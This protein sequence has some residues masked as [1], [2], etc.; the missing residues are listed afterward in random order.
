M[1]IFL[2]IN[3]FLYFLI[4]CNKNINKNE[5][6]LDESNFEPWPFKIYEFDSEGNILNSEIDI[7]DFQHSRDCQ[8]CHPNHV[9]EWKLSSHYRA[10]NSQIFKITFENAKESH[11]NEGDRFC[12][13]CHSPQL[14]VTGLFESDLEDNSLASEI[15]SENIGCDFC[16]TQ[17]RLNFN[18]L[19]VDDHSLIDAEYFINPGEGIKYGSIVDPDTNN[20][21]HHSVYNSIYKDSRTCLPCHN[22]VIRDVP[23]HMTM[24]EW[25]SDP[26]NDMADNRSCQSCHM[27]YNG[28]YHSHMF[29]GIDIDLT[30]SLDHEDNQ[31]RIAS[32]T[33]LLDSAAI[34]YFSNSQ[35][36]IKS[37]TFSNDTLK[38]PFTIQNKTAHN[39]PTGTSEL[40]EAWIELVVY[41]KNDEPICEFGTIESN[42][43]FLKYNSHNIIFTSWL[44]NG[45]DTVYSS[46][47]A[48][49]IINNSLKINETFEW[50]YSCY[51]PADIQDYVKVKSRMRIRPVKPQLFYSDPAFNEYFYLLDNIPIFDI[52]QSKIE[53]IVYVN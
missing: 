49:D 27:S 30:K 14:F 52:E 4:S 53:K 47:E 37:Y 33:S 20:N 35:D 28:E 45:Q 15:A 23:V 51:I 39:I 24:A 18:S 9:E 11:F 43:D 32:I 40:R 19:D 46:I 17:T 1:K 22:M 31:R 2:Y 25:A 26:F 10:T 48:Y 36:S 5:S 29:S 34:S 8:S 38:I 7:L 6:V 12:S 13:Q 3:F 21:F 42:R 44:K 16:H 50:M 41:D